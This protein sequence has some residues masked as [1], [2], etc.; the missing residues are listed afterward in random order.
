MP[1]CR[2]SLREVIGNH[3]ARC[4]MSGSYPELRVQVAAERFRVPD[5]VVLRSG[6]PVEAIVRVPPLLCIEVLVEGRPH[7]RDAGEG[8]GLSR[9]GS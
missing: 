7:E 6:A 2:D 5:V 8:R 9:H 4:G 1:V 3:A